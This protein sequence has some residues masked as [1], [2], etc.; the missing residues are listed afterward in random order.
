MKKKMVLI[1][2]AVLLVCA[3][4]V[5]ISVLASENKAPAATEETIS[6][7]PA[8]NTDSTEKIVAEEQTFAIPAPE[9]LSKVTEAGTEVIGAETL[10]KLRVVLDSAGTDLTLEKATQ[11]SEAVQK[12]YEGSETTFILN[13]FTLPISNVAKWSETVLFEKP[14][15][16]GMKMGSGEL[17]AARRAQIEQIN[18]MIV[19]SLIAL[20]PSD[21]VL[22]QSVFMTFDEMCVSNFGAYLYTD[23][24]LLDGEYDSLAEAIE[25]VRASSDRIAYIKCTG[26]SA[27][28]HCGDTRIELTLN[29]WS[30]EEYLAYWREFEKTDEYRQMLEEYE[31]LHG[32]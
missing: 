5:T 27:Y 6:D 31:R 14:S 26:Q 15:A 21:N 18:Q 32:N 22:P 9:L 2:A 20:S 28:Y 19:Y 11:I 29:P 16:A 30:S 7:Q 25:L 8:E 1:V 3:L 10:A 12:L 24:I 23:Y 17:A 4:T 13:E